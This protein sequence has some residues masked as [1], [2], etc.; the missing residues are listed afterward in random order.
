[1][2]SLFRALDEQWN[3]RGRALLASEVHVQELLHAD[4]EVGHLSLPAQR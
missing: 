1:M 4:C 3:P 2:I